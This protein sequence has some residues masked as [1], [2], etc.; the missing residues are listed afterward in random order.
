M[1][2]EHSDIDRH[3]RWPDVKKKV[4][5]DPRYRA[6]DSSSTREDWFREYCK[7]LKD[8]KRR[9]KEKDREHRRE[10]E[11]KKERRESGG[12][13]GEKR[14]RGT[15]ESAGEEGEEGKVSDDEKKDEKKE[16]EK[17][18]QART[19]ASLREREKEVQR[20]LA[21]HL[22]DRDK[23]REQ[24]KRDEAVQHF[25]ALLADLVRNAE[26][27]WKEAKRQLRKDHRWDLADLLSR[28]EKEK[29]FNEHTDQ[30]SKK[31][32]DKFREMLDEV[33][34]LSLTS[35]WKDIKKLIKEDSRY[36]KFSASSERV[37]KIFDNL[38]Y[39]G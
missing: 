23:E 1:L 36:V 19:E 16:K 5:S 32:R 31:K 35:H 26:L 10:K 28:D 3:T 37:S 14:K 27:T 7:I 6:V 2:R 30:L 12:E 33:A 20:T 34:D 4:D 18:K 8:E 38:L 9:A 13:K 24:H 22:R 11:R 17:E 25:S 21:T 39:A 29:L 15:D